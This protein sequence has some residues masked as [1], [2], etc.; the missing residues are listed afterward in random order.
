MSRLVYLQR[1]LGAV[2]ALTYCF[3]VTSVTSVV[4]VQGPWRQLAVLSLCLQ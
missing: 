2:R 4:K 3:W 1:A